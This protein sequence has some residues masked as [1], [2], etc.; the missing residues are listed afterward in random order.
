MTC[1]EVQ[2]ILSGYMLDALDPQEMGDV[3]VHLAVCREHDDD[4]VHLRATSMALAL[5]DEAAHPSAHLRARVLAA[6]GPTAV[7]RPAPLEDLDD[8]DEADDVDDDIDDDIADDFEDD[9]D[10]ADGLDSDS[11]AG[12]RT[13]R[14]DGRPRSRGPL[15]LPWWFAGIAAAIALV[16]F[17]AGWYAGLRSAPPPQTT[18]RY[19]FEMRGADG[20]LVRFAGIEGSERVTVTMD[21]LKAAPEG[22]QYQVW[23][24]RDGTWVSLGSCNTNTKGWWKG[25]FEFRLQ[26]GEEVALTV[27]P[28]GGSP[29]PSS[30]SILRTKF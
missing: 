11:D 28:S 20:Q 13:P 7:P 27:E 19:S 22:R 6:A 26:R 10:D 23:A 16:M 2:D 21:G 30:P 24:I 25:D 14:L 4:L 5:L 8:V 18:V 12:A 1:N 17:G 15:A 3:E 9:A 29:K